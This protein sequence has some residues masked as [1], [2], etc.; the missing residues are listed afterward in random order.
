[1]VNLSQVEKSKVSA[2]KQRIFEELRNAGVSWLGAHRFSGMHL[3]K[4]IHHGEHIT[5]AVFGRHRE[6]E[7]FFGMVEGM[8]VATDRRVFY[9][10][11][12]P[13]YTTMDEIIYRVVT[14]INVTNT[15][16]YASLTLFTKIANYTLSYARPRAV[17]QFADYVEQRMGRD[18]NLDQS[19][20]SEPD[21]TTSSPFLLIPEDD[22]PVGIFLREHEIGVLSSIERTGFVSG[23]TIYFTPYR[24]KLYFI[25][26]STTR[27]SSSIL[28]NRYVALTVYD[29]AKLQTAQIQGV[30]E[31][32]EDEATKQYVSKMIVRPRKYASGS[33]LPPV[34]GLKG[35]SFIVFRI[36]PTKINFNDYKAS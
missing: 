3:V 14:G 7:G 33:H 30:V 23:A 13:G 1:M 11:H 34:V 21:L 8:L 31:V 26:K 36:T 16:P 22:S 24:G 29:E 2:E 19:D 4:V 17:K 20:I 27:K 10:D 9:I 25:T 18:E 15:I 28:G 32:E 6:A 5:A 12:R 35:D